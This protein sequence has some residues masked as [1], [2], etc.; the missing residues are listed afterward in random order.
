M[1]V[2]REALPMDGDEAGHP[3]TRLVFESAQAP[4]DFCD[5]LGALLPHSICGAPS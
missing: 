1:Q 3:D 5:S 2:T 4:G